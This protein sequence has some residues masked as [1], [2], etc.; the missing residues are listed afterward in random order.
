MKIAFIIT[1]NT[2]NLEPIFGLYN[3]ILLRNMRYRRCARRFLQ[4]KEKSGNKALKYRKMVGAVI[5]LP[6]CLRHF[7]RGIA[8]TRNFSDSNKKACKTQFLQALIH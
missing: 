6:G 4:L 1:V 8:D 7:C 5:N 2:A 3:K